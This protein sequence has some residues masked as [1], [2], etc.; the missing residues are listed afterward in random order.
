[1]FADVCW[2]WRVLIMVVVCGMEVKNVGVG[3]RKRNETDTWF[4]LCGGTRTDQRAQLSDV[5]NAKHLSK[6]MRCIGS[7]FC[8]GQATFRGC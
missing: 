3:E 7:L 8:A 5:A 6:R 4:S 2:W 1:M